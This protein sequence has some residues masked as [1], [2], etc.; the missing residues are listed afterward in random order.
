MVQHS[1]YAFL[2][3]V[4]GIHRTLIFFPEGSVFH[5]LIIHFH[6]FCVNVP[7]VMDTHTHVSGFDDVL[8]TA[9][10]I[11]E[12]T[13]NAKINTHG[14]DELLCC[15]RVLLLQNTDCNFRKKYRQ[16]R[17]DSRHDRVYKNTRKLLFITLK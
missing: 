3:V 6:G 2:I 15:C 14:C 8:Q 9:H 12:H 17:I 10:C 7:Y 1:L 16:K 11:A 5:V 13:R 4:A